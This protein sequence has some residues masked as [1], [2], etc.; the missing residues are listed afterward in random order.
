MDLG[1][2]DQPSLPVHTLVIQYS[3]V[4]YHLH[5]ISSPGGDDNTWHCSKLLSISWDPERDGVFLQLLPDLFAY[6]HHSPE[7]RGPN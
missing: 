3:E 2:S 6:F 1:E 7:E 5:T 4:S